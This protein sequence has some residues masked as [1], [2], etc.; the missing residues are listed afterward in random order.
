[1]MTDGSTTAN[2]IG[3]GNVVIDRSATLSRD[4]ILALGYPEKATS[5]ID[6]DVA[7][8]ISQKFSWDNSSAGGS[9]GNTMATVA[10]LTKIFGG[11]TVASSIEFHGMASHDHAAMVFED[12]FAEHG[13]KARLYK[14]DKSHTGQ[15]FCLIDET[16][17]ERT[18]LANLGSNIYFH[19]KYLD[20]DYLAKTHLLFLEGYLFD[21]HDS[22]T[23]FTNIVKNKTLEQKIALTLSDHFCVNRHGTD[24]LALI[25]QGIDIVFANEAE[26]IALTNS[27][28]FE[29]ALLVA[30]DLAPLVIITR[31]EKGVMILEKEKSPLTISAKKNIKVIDATG[32]GDQL[33]GGFLFGYH[34]G[35]SHEKSAR[36]GCHLAATIIGQVGARLAIDKNMVSDFL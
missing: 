32:A 27:D 33:A 36:L 21:N 18:M 2:M 7:V 16:S 10:A 22:K 24:F 28:D 9:V 30:K 13:G 3:I 29:A 26:I 17:G 11:T 1:M 4:V 35:W 8:M 31:S 15:C 19:T 12:S 5:L 25:K 14:I 6:D 23:A 34:Y 20:G